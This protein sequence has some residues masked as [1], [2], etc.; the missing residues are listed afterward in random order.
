M[1]NRKNYKAVS[2]NRSSKNKKTSRR[3]S[4]EN[5]KFIKTKVLGFPS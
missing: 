5:R 2:Q 3:K 1:E 4:E